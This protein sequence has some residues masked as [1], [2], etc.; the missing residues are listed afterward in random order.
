[1]ATLY[2]AQAY[3]HYDNKNGVT[4]EM[5]SDIFNGLTNTDGPYI[6]GNN[7]NIHYLGIQTCPGVQFIIDNNQTSNN[8]TIRVGQTGI[9][10]L[11][12]QDTDAI[13]IVTFKNLKT[14]L[15]QASDLNNVNYCLI[16]V[17]YSKVNS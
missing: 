7:F 3:G 2:I 16:D 17:I 6:G 11:N 9:F 5:T 10:E 4:F 1:M 12:L 13:K 8:G 14:M 15:Q